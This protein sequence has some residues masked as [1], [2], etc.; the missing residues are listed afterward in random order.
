MIA[1]VLNSLVSDV[2]IAP[3][4]SLDTPKQITSGNPTIARHSWL[5]DNDTIVYRDLSGRLNAVHKDGS[6]FTL[7]VPEG[8]KAAGGVSACGDGPYVVFQV[9]PGSN[10]WRV[11]PA[12]GGARQLTSGY[13]DAN[14]VCTA[15]GKWVMYSSTRQGVNSIWR[16]PIEGG[17]PAQVRPGETFEV[18][19]SPGGRF[20]YYSAFEWD[21]QPAPLRRLRW[22]VTSSE[23]GKRVFSVN[24]P[25]DKAIGTVPVWAPDDSGLDYVVTRKGVSNIWRQP[26]TGGSP[27]QV[28]NFKA[29]KIFSFAWSPDGKWLS[30]ASGSNRSDV[31]LISRK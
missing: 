24:V 15:D 17:E 8:H 5:P 7:A 25:S 6:T 21:Q 11:T 20:I 31:V 13:P 22:I 10:I 26:L 2:W 30:L 19:P 27:V 9:F 28:T 14:P 3:S 18:L 16:I 23:D 12:A 29:L 4:D 1:G